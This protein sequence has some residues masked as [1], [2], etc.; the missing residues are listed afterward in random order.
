M[1][2]SETGRFDFADA[3]HENV[4]LPYVGFAAYVLRRYNYASPRTASTVSASAAFACNLYLPR[5]PTKVEHIFFTNMTLLS[6]LIVVFTLLMAVG[7]CG[8]IDTHFHA[9]PADYIQAV[10]ANGGDPSGYPTPEWSIEA[11]VQ[12]MDEIGTQLG[13]STVIAHMIIKDRSI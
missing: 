8:R 12:S 7:S 11:A 2:I 4:R 6:K 9:L 10:K 3:L 1:P 13:M 5:L